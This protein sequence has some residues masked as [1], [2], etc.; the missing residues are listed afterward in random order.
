MKSLWH[1]NKFDYPSLK[2]GWNEDNGSHKNQADRD[3]RSHS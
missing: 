3:Q 1:F 2:I